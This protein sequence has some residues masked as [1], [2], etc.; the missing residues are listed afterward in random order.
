[1]ITAMGYGIT[2]PSA[3]DSGTRRIRENIP[4]VCIPGST[5]HRLRPATRRSSP[6]TPTEFVTE[7]Y[8]CAGDSGSGAFDQATFSR[9]ALRTCS[10]RSRADRRRRRNA[11]PPCTP[12][13]TRTPRSSSRARSA[14]PQQGH[15]PT[16]SWAVM[17]EAAGRRRKGC[18]GETCT[19]VDATDPTSA[20]SDAASGPKTVGLC[21]VGHSVAARRFPGSALGVLAPRGPVRLAPPPLLNQRNVVPWRR[22]RSCPRPS[23]RDRRSCCRPRSTL[24]PASAAVQARDHGR[25]SSSR[26]TWRASRSRRSRR[27][28]TS[29]SG[30]WR[31]PSM[32]FMSGSARRRRTAAACRSPPAERATG[33]AS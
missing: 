32:A 10:E 27:S 5:D 4:M 20:A 1:M 12:A 18:D 33:T 24:R 9:P 6:T 23:P 25:A 30:A 8:V 21:D 17:S 2:D 16:P 22:F 11:S 13:P 14:R 29:R 31:S 28:S 15:Y 7:G 26:A 19:V 3:T